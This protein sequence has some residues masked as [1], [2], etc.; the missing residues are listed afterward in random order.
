M[1]I[2]RALKESPDTWAD[3]K[4]DIPISG[5]PGYNVI[6]TSFTAGNSFNGQYR[7]VRFIFKANGGDTAYNGLNVLAIYAYGGVGWTTPT[8]LAKTNHLYSIDVDTNG[9]FVGSFP[10]NVSG[11]SGSCTGNSVTA[12]TARNA[13]NTIAICSTESAT[14]AKTATLDG[15]ALTSGDRIPLYMTNNNTASTPTLN[16]N[17]TGAKTIRINGSTVV[18]ATHKNLPAGFYMTEHTGTCTTW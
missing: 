4:T 9:N 12:T 6:Q 18:T 5:W 8:T 7:K 14:V 11:S 2:Q 1:T 13:R 16:V 15:Y 17:S 10:G 3:Y